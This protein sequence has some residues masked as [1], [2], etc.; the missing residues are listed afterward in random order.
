VLHDLG[1]GPALVRHAAE[2][3]ELLGIT[4]SVKTE[5]LG[6]RRL[7]AAVETSLYRIAQEA[8][9]NVGKHARATRASVVLKRGRSAVEL[10][11]KDEGRGFR[12]ER[13]LPA[14]TASGRL[15]LHDIRERTALLGGE[16]SIVSKPGKGTTVSVRI[17]LRKT[18]PPPPERH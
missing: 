1:L 5:G 12:V 3:G 7:P 9:A 13:A 18:K 17:P 8:I 4:I 6:S 16:A 14:A 15:G 2:H 11:V 10:T